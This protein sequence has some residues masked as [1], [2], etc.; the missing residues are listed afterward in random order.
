MDKNITKFLIIGRP[1]VGKSTLINKILR[2]RKVITV[3]EPGA[4]RDIN[5]IPAKWN[6]KSFLIADSGGV[7]LTDSSDIKFQNKIE[8]QMKKALK[9]ATKV[10]FITDAQE[11]L[12]PIDKSIAT[13]LRKS[14]KKVILI[15]NKV[16]NEVIEANTKEFLQLG[17]GD[18]FCIATAHGKGVSKLLDNITRDV[19]KKEKWPEE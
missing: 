10:L 6:E 13:F 9:D 18:P 3:D 14:A 2:Q 16:D 1:N 17:L 4:T 12:H 5:Y 11:G 7:F 19:T 15:S 8:E